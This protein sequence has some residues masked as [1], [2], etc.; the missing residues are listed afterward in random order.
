MIF[1]LQVDLLNIREKLVVALVG[2]QINLV[3]FTV[4]GMDLKSRIFL[5]N[6]IKI[7]QI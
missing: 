7:F 6:K 3:E 4:K 2:Y 5:E 1:L